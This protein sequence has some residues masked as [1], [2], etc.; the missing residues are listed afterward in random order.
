MLFL[1]KTQICQFHLEQIWR[2]NT[3]LNDT[4]LNDIQYTKNA[5]LGKIRF[6]AKTVSCLSYCPI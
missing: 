2:Q 4:H 3:L 6:V 5:A 1:M